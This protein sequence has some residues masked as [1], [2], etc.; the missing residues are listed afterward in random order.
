MNANEKK[1]NVIKDIIANADHDKAKAK[2]NEINS[3]ANANVKANDIIFSDML[4]SLDKSLFVTNKGTS[5]ENIYKVSLF[6]NLTDKEKKSLR[7]KIRSIRESFIYSFLRT[8]NKDSLQKLFVQFKLFCES[9]Y[10]FEFSVEN[11]KTE[12]FCSANTSETEKQNINKAIE[13]IKK[14]F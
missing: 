4:K 6:T 1:A 9:T 3:I 14:L 12:N 7:R 2:A 11:I 10:N 8:E 5:K 13:I